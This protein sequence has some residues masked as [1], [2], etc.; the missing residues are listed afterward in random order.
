MLVEFPF[1]PKELDL[2]FD[3]SNFL[4]EREALVKKL[5]PQVD[6]YIAKRVTLKPGVQQ[7]LHKQGFPDYILTLLKHEL[8]DHFNLNPEQALIFSEFS[9]IDMLT[10]GFFFN[11]ESYG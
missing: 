4:D 7:S 9:L 3:I 10:D 8:I 2:L 1:S 5:K 11:E 6:N